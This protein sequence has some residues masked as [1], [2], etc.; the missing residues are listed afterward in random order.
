VFASLGKVL[1]DVIQGFNALAERVAPFSPEISQA[2][3][4]LQI[5]EIDFASNV[6]TQSGGQLGRLYEASGEIW[7][8]I[9]SILY[10]ISR[11]FLS[12]IV[13]AV[14]TLRDFI[15]GVMS[16]SAMVRDMFVSFGQL[17]T[18]FTGN[19]WTQAKTDFIND[20]LS[21]IDKWWYGKS[22]KDTVES[23]L[24]FTNIAIA[25]SGLT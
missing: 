3:A 5:K 8:D 23:D 6:A 13:P 7:L 22:D 25:T 12:I 10:E 14:E 24:T 4:S 21:A 19:D 16:F 17:L 15:K 9:Q 18:I 2:K 1:V 11:P 20:F